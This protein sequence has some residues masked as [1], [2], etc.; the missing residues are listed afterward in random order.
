[1]TLVATQELLINARRDE[2]GI[3]AFN[4]IGIEHAE[5]IVIGAESVNAPVILQLSAN[6]IKY[7]GG[8]I[9]PIGRA[10]AEIANA[11]AVPVALHLDH[12]TSRVLCEAAVTYGFSSVMLDTS[13]LPYVDNLAQTAELVCW[14]H[15]QGVAVEAGLG[16]V[17]GK[18]EAVTTR[19]GMTDPAAARAFVA[20]TGADSLAVAIG[21]THGMG[22]RTARLDLDLLARIRAAVDVPLVLHGSSGVPDEGLAAAVAGGITKIN[23]ATQLN[24]AFTGAVRRYLANDAIVSDPRT[25][26]TEAR[27]A[28]AACVADRLRLLG[29]AGRG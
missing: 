9:A 12:A 15:G 7:H 27:S 13:D 2:Y 6:A 23:L 18:D 19:A 29:A 20:E 28:V 1:M 25:Y 8:A 16:T 24:Q 4:V 10:C 21:T 17:G 5:G 3:P 26:L 14:A 11:S 22:E